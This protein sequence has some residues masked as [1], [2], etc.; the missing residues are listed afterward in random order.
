[1][2]FMDFLVD[3]R[4]ADIGPDLEVFFHGEKRED[5]PPLGDVDDPA[6]DDIVGRLPYALL[7]AKLYRPR[8][9]F[10]KPGNRPQQGTLP[11]SNCPNNKFNSPSSICRSMSKSTCTSP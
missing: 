11:S 5:S 8:S 10:Q 2:S 3:L 1:M 9:L 6:R 4:P 7:P